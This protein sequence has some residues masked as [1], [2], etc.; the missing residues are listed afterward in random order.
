NKSF[1]L[2][3]IFRTKSSAAEHDN[4]RILSLQFGKLAMF[5]GVIG[6]LVI[7]KYRSGDNVTTHRYSLLRSHEF[8]YQRRDLICF[9]IE[10][11]VSCV[12]NIDFCLRYILA[13]TVRLARIEGEIILA[14]DHQQARLLV[15]HPCLPFRIGVNVRSIIVEQVA[16]N[17]RLTRLVEEIIFVRP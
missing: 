6:K 16:L 13:K 15:T 1:M 9:G 12:E 11:E 10:C 3:A 7:G 5:S 4:H 14:P 2:T 17:L 8:T